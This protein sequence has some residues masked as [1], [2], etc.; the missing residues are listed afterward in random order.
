MNLC[1]TATISIWFYFSGDL[2]ISI[3][4]NNSVVC[5]VIHFLPILA[6]SLGICSHKTWLEQKSFFAS[7]RTVQRH[8]LNKSYII[9]VYLISCVHPRHQYHSLNVARHDRKY[10]SYKGCSSFNDCLLWWFN[11][12]LIKSGVFEQ[13]YTGVPTS[14]RFTSES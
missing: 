2:R 5:R 10:V 9:W 12:H 8:L 11:T 13:G 6:F 7:Y 3:L 14:I 4:S 1:L